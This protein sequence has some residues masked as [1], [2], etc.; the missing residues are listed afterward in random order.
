MSR[1]ESQPLNATGLS[2]K[3]MAWSVVT[4]EYTNVSDTNEHEVDGKVQPFI[5]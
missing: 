4:V 3:R 2:K 1:E 5:I